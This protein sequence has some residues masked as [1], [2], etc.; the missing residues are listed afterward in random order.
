LIPEREL[1]ALGCLSQRFYLLSG[2]REG[3]ARQHPFAG[4][5]DGEL[6][7]GLHIVDPDR[8]LE[9]RSLVV[10]SYTVVDENTRVYE[11]T[12][13]ANGEPGYTYRVTVTDHGPDTKTSRK[14][15]SS[16]PPASGSSSAPSSRFAAMSAST[17]RVRNPDP[18]SRD[19]P[20]TA[21]DL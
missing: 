9:V 10:M 15:R 5:Q 3:N 6:W 12:A 17:S 11:G 2:R 21:T 18:L 14:S 4:Y 8:G 20:A 1:E 16:I 13:T 7:G 19:R